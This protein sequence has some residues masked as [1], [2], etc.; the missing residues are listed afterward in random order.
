MFRKQCN[1]V[2]ATGVSTIHP[3]YMH[4]SGSKGVSATRK[5]PVRLTVGF[6]KS[7]ILRGQDDALVPIDVCGIVV[8]SRP[9]GTKGPVLYW[10]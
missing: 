8:L 7:L 6:Q 5:T 9:L 10:V 3:S 1:R 4:S 2:P